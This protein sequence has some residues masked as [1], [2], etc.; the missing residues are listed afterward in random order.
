MEHA[1]RAAAFFLA[2][3]LPL[4]ASAAWY[5]DKSIEWWMIVFSKMS[6]E[7][8][9]DVGDIYHPANL[10]KRNKCVYEAD[11]STE[12]ATASIGCE[13]TMKTGFLFATDKA[14]CEIMLQQLKDK[15]KD[16]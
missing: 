4:S 10:V 3:F 13:K 15:L 1:M 12:G 8:A 5:E 11:N 2:V 14:N 16:F 9:K 6:C 7:K